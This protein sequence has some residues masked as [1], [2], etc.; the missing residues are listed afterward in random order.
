[1]S[2]YSNLLEPNIMENFETYQ[3]GTTENHFS[4]EYWRGELSN[5]LLNNNLERSLLK[6]LESVD[7][8]FGTK[9]GFFDF[10]NAKANRASL[11]V[12][13][14]VVDTIKLYLSKLEEDTS[15]LEVIKARLNIKM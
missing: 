15:T 6:G 5:L 13:K 10:Q 9:K 8:Y 4:V 1:M 14:R 11:V 7:P 3:A 12:T 2:K